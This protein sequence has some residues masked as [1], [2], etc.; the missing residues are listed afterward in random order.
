MDAFDD[1]AAG[2]RGEVEAMQDAMRLASED[3]RKLSETLGKDLKGAV[4]ALVFD[5]ASL[6]DTLRNLGR[7]MLETGLNAAV[8]PLKDLMG[9]TVEGLLSGPVKAFAKGGVVTAPTTFPMSGATGL[10][11][12]AGAEAIM[13]LT[14]GTDGSLGVRAASGGQ[15]VQVVMNI[16]TPDVQGFRRSQSQIAAQMGRMLERGQRNR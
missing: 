7:S 4:N 10:M 16:S 12:E 13:P 11:G 9:S 1:D 2:F 8:N 14:R 15:P 3:A 5:G 6:S